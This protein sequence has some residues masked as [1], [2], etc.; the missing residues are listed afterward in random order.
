MGWQAAVQSVF[1][2]ALY[3]SRQ[4]VAQNVFQSASYYSLQAAV[5]SAFQT[6]LYCNQRTD[7]FSEVQSRHLPCGKEYLPDWKMKYYFVAAFQMFS[8]SLALR[9]QKSFVP[10]YGFPTDQLSENN[11]Q[12]ERFFRH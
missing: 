5:Q 3:C 9:I 1:Q 12:A 8:L 2:S 10:H 11:C 7:P 4:A 6:D